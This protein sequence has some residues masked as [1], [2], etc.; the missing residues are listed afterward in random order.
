MQAPRAVGAKAALPKDF[1]ADGRSKESAKKPK[2]EREMAEEYG[3]FMTEVE[4]DAAQVAQEEAEATAHAVEDVEDREAFV[5]VV[6]QSRVERL[7]EAWA[8]KQRHI[9]EDANLAAQAMTQFQDAADGAPEAH[10][11]ESEAEDD[12]AVDWRARGILSSKMH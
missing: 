4:S 7:K 11:D 10:E 6:H 3:A 8:S 9:E 2:T 5:Q 1:F 12:P